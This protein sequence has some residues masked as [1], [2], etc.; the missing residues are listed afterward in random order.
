MTTP[1]LNAQQAAESMKEIVDWGKSVGASVSDVREVPSFFT[2]FETT[3][4][5]QAGS[6]VR[7]HCKFFIA[8]YFLM[9]VLG[10]RRLPAHP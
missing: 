3:F 8:A 2:F 6:E 10:S 9:A 5:G 4:L 7:H 1:K